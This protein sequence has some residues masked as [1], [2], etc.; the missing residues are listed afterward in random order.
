[1]HLSVL[2]FF[3]LPMTPTNLFLNVV[4]YALNVI[5][6][7]CICAIYVDWLHTNTMFAVVYMMPNIS[8][9]MNRSFKAFYVQ[10]FNVLTTYTYISSNIFVP[11]FFCLFDGSSMLLFTI[12]FA[13]FFFPLK[14]NS[15]FLL[16]YWCLFM[17]VQFFTRGKLMKHTH[18]N[19]CKA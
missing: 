2:T 17:T 1:M 8:V 19:D 3:I 6:E 7:L 5:V 18:V 15:I 11:L 13:D 4:A 14:I 9:A 12:P 10:T 16:L